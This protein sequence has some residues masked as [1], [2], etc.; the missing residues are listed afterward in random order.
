MCVGEPFV[1]NNIFYIVT[2]LMLKYKMSPPDGVPLS[3]DSKEGTF[4]KTPNTW[5]ICF[6]M[7]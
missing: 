3:T 7:R 2:R 6:T 4:V 5:T 1:R